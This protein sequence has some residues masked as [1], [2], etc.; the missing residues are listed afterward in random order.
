MRDRTTHA[1][2][3]KFGARN[4]GVTESGKDSRLT[5]QGNEVQTIETGA[6]EGYALLLA[7]AGVAEW[8]TRRI[9]NPVPPKGVWVQVPP[10]AL[11]EPLR[12]S[13]RMGG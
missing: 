13:G 5:A 6:D 12:P 3:Q 1:P 8:Q 11:P 10:P 9:Q 4:G 7:N 2:T